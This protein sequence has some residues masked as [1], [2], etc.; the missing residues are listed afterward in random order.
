M[1]FYI[2]SAGYSQQHY[3]VL[4]FECPFENMGST[5]EQQ[6]TKKNKY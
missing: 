5:M 4:S 3:P 2:Q 6:H 1:L